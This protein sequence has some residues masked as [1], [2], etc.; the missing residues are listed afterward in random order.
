MKKRIGIF[1]ISFFLLILFGGCQ[2][3]E[4]TKK[5]DNKMEG[6]EHLY[7]NNEYGYYFDIYSEISK[8]KERNGIINIEN[9]SDNLYMKVENA[10]K[11]RKM[12]IQIFIDYVQVPILIDDQEYFTYIIDADD[13]FSEELCFKLSNE[14]DES[15][16][17]KIM[18]IMTASADINEIHRD[19]KRTSNAYSIAYDM[20]LELD[21]NDKQVLMTD[22]TYDYEEA[23]YIYRDMWEGLIINSDLEEFKRKLPQKSIEVKPNEEIE[24]QYHVGGYSDCQEVLIILSLDMKQIEANAQKYLKCNVADGEIHN[25]IL[26]INA[27]DEAGLYDLTGWVI[28]DPFSESAPQYFPLSAMPRFTINVCE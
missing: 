22:K 1:V 4:D 8:N 11:K 5:Y 7:A 3:K 15:I 12:A 21:S 9:S 18:A 23:R 13:K 2:L 25:G 6:M 17:H 14:I 27:P 26:K 10:G 19:D 24:L 28:K 16:N 20:I